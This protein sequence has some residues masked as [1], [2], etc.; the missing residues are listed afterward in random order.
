M[1]KSEEKTEQTKEEI[2]KEG[3]NTKFYTFFDSLSRTR[4]SCLKTYTPTYRYKEAE[5]SLTL[6]PNEYY[7]MN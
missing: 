1:I 3:R 4:N 5:P 6:P 2:P 7:S